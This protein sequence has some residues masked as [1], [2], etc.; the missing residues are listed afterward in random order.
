[1]NGGMRMRRVFAFCSALL[2]F[3]AVPI[4]AKAE[5]VSVSS[6]A[7]VLYEP[8]SGR[9]LFAKNADEK[10]PMASTTK[11][12]T[13]LIAAEQLSADSVVTVPEEAVRVEGSAVGLRGG[14]TLTVRDLLAGLLLSSG[15]DAANALALLCDNSLEAF[16]V[17]MNQQAA[18]LGMS[19][20]VFVTPS[21]LD[22]GD[23]ASTVRDMALLGAAALKQPLVA[24]LCQTKQTA[25]AINGTPIT[26]T[27]HN[28]LLW[29]YEDAV[30]LKTGFTKKSGKC[31]VS[32]AERDGVTLV[33]ATFNGGDYW[34][35]HISLYEYGFAQTVSVPLKTPALPTVTVCGGVTSSVAVESDTLSEVVLFKDEA[36]LLKTEWQ[37]PPFV[38]APVTAGESVGTLQYTV[39][40][41]VVAEA[42]LKIKETVA[43]REATPFYKKWQK[44]W[45][46]LWH[47]VI[48]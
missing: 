29:L 4:S 47:A 7:A 37:L 16:A 19:R 8:Q 2:L 48:K 35:D 1:M 12:M 17:R 43:A 13:A 18:R 6:F 11:L 23:H 3:A 28:R 24:T 27:N 25:I 36:A 40:D 5:A 34:N 20:T 21:G 39:N 31:L 30:G 44:Q 10:R 42:P 22:K 26:I 41:R 32:A 9:V 46:V 15:N 45:G 33:C 14:D 38:W